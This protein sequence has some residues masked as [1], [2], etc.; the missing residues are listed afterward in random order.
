MARTKQTAR[1]EVNRRKYPQKR[2]RYGWREETLALQTRDSCTS[3]NP[4][5]S[6][7]YEVVYPQKSDR[8]RKVPIALTQ[9]QGANEKEVPEVLFN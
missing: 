4:S 6:E 7:I 5:P 3:G 8:N 2:S 9:Y 1:T